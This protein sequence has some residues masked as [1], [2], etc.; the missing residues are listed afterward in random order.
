M[1][2]VR[3]CA[4]AGRGKPPLPTATAGFP[5]SALAPRR[6]VR[7]IRGVAIYIFQSGKDPRRFAYTTDKSG[8]GLP[9]DLGPWR[10]WGGQAVQQIP[11]NPWSNETK[12]SEKKLKIAAII[13]LPFCEF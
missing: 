3:I 7:Y 4:G 9:D 8:A 2:H 1:P 10:P 5:T 6:A 13:S 11:A 12:G